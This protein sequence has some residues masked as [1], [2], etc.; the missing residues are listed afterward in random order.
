MSETTHAPGPWR[1]SQAYEIGQR[2][3]WCL[4]NDESAAE[5]KTIDYCLVSIHSSEKYLGGLFLENLNGRLVGLAL[6]IIEACQQ[7]LALCEEKYECSDTR[8][9]DGC[10]L[11]MARDAIQKATGKESKDVQID[12]SWDRYMH[13]D[14]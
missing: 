9:R 14:L 5:G 7:L 8:F 2:L 12:G 1:W 6:E 13:L 4:E 3:H 11:C 10:T